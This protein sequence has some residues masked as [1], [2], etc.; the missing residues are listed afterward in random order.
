MA[1]AG[2]SKGPGRKALWVRVPPPAP[3]LRIVTTRIEPV[4][5]RVLL[6][7]ALLSPVWAADPAFAQRRDFVG[8]VVSIDA[9]SLHVKDRRGNEMSFVRADNA[10]VEGKSDW[11]AIAPGDKVLVRWNLTTK[12]ARHVVVLEGPPKASER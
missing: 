5:A 10:V 7:L 6:L 2:P 4:A 11:G 3:G 12:I 8:R 9:Q 1:Y